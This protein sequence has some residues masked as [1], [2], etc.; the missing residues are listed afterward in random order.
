MALLV[1]AV[2]FPV[3]NEPLV[4]LP[5]PQSGR[6]SQSLY[7]CAPYRLIGKPHALEL[8]FE[9]YPLIGTVMIVFEPAA[10]SAL[11]KRLTEESVGMLVALLSLM[12]S[13][14][15]SIA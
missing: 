5:L 6:H 1:S 11:M 10:L 9:T 8:L 4:C 2:L 3:I 7:C 12:F 15:Q 14:Y 13:K